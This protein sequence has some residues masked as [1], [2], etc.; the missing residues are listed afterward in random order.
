MT[1]NT[2]YQIARTKGMSDALAK[3]IAAQAAHETGGFTSR[4]FQSN[5]NA[6]GM[7][8]A[9]QLLALGEK[10]GY[11]NYSNLG[12]SVEDLIAWYNRKRSLGA[13][14]FTPVTTLDQ[15]VLFL[16]TNR[17]FEAPLNE[18]LNG[19]RHF[20]FKLFPVE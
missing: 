19:C 10:N 7:K 2:I 18:Y 4:I 8:Y 16:K 20:Y 13:Y 11:A 1:G 12:K 15:Y 6:F 9:G 14:I 3:F 5:N 17:Y